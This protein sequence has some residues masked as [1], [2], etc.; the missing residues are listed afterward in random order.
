M[1]KR[2][3]LK[4]LALTIL[5]LLTSCI[6]IDES[7]RLFF[8]ANLKELQFVQTQFSAFWWNFIIIEPTGQKKNQPNFEVAQKICD[9]LKTHVDQQLRHV[10]CGSSIASAQKILKSYAQD[11]VFRQEFDSN[12]EKQYLSIVK[13]AAVQASFISDKNLFA[14]LRYDPFQTWQEYLTISKSS[15]IDAFERKDGFLYDAKTARLIIPLQF[16]LSPQM[17]TVEPIM[18]FLNNYPDA[19][20]VGSHG[21]T[22]RNEKQVRDDLSIVSI[23]SG[24]IFVIFIVFLVLKS[25]LNTLLLVLPVGVAMGLATLITQWI[26]GSVHGLTLAFGSGIVGLALDYGL[27]GAF[28]SES[29]QTWVSNTIG[30][31]TT[32]SGVCIL[33]LSGIPLIRQMMIFSSIGLAIGFGIFFF[34]FKY[35]AHFFKIKTIPFMLPQIKGAYWAVVLLVLFGIYG[36]SKSEMTMDLKKLSFVSDK[37]ADLTT[38]FFTKND[39]GESFLLIKPFSEVNPETYLENTWA[40]KNGID[41]EGIS[42]YVPAVDQQ[43][44]NVSSWNQF[45]CKFFKNKAD[46]DIQKIYA[47]F[48]QTVCLP[49]TMNSL[50]D[51]TNQQ[52]KEKAYF[53]HLIGQNHILSIFS[54]HTAEQSDL[55]RTQYPKAK[56]LTQALKDF[57]I[58]LEHDLTWMIP[59]SLLLTIL[60]L[61][62]YYRHWKPVFTALLPFF[63][64]LGL[65]FSVAQIMG[66]EVDL[67]AIL[68]LVMVFG[69]SIDYGVFSTDIH[70]HSDSEA[71]IKGVYSALTFA[72]LTNVLGFLPML[73][74][75]HPV[76]SHL[77]GALFYGTVGTYLGTI[78]GVYPI[79]KKR[80][81]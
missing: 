69:F 74:A 10:F 5:L 65:Y 59:V 32:L 40:K 6:R 66:F 53:N 48:I 19:F 68:G 49:A 63:T 34:L 16:Q 1:L 14:L 81:A 77:G 29:K 43:Q 70:R 72:A 46:S 26:D 54:A 67:I 45:G 55:I 80:K 23:M 57:S 8:P 12:N 42:K 36:V 3:V 62:L 20:L 25:R 78:Y 50:G 75:G 18:T 17:V 37:E 64:G 15:F 31:L 44:K 22:Y 2:S 61:A 7:M 9:Q 13:N 56:S 11:I 58:G 38:W 39:N 35:Y 4:Y 79:Y 21:S 51:F 60:I 27:H 41:Y 73:F 52:M 28:G 30:L 33:L 47:P 76:L 24:I 71:E